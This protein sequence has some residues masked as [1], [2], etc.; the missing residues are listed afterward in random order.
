MRRFVPLIALAAV[1]LTA[2][3]GP[4]PATQTHSFACAWKA[5]RST[6]FG[7]ANPVRRAATALEALEAASMAGEF[8]YHVQE[9]SFGPYVDQIGRYRGRGLERL[10]VQGQRR[11]ATGRRRQGRAEGRGRGALVLGDVHGCGRARRRSSC[12]SEAGCYRVF[13]QDDAGRQSPCADAFLRVG[14]AE[15]RGRV[16]RARASGTHRGL[17][18]ATVRRAP[19]GRTRCRDAQARSTA[20]RRRR[21]APGCGGERRRRRGDAVGDARPRRRGAGDG[22][23]A[24]GRDGHA[25]AA[26]ARRTST[27]GYGGRFVQ[28]IEGVAGD[29]G[30]KRDWFYFVNGVEADRGA[31]EYRLRPGDVLGGTTGRG[32]ATTCASRS[33]SAPSPSRSSTATTDACGRSRFVSRRRRCGEPPSG[34]RI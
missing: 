8:Y 14:T 30:A 6:L 2:A 16:R 24:R 5:R 12:V 20:L 34:S 1:L 10:G 4:S 13:A 26:D 18:R 3:A 32:R 17:V 33:S 19:C 21:A 28:S 7:A 23:R 22:D 31:A 25:G 11:V 15:V 29:A 9:T 27:R